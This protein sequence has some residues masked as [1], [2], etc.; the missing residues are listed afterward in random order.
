MAHKA[1]AFV[2]AVRQGHKTGLFHSWAET[3]VCVQGFSGAEHKKFASQEEA[4]RWLALKRPAPPPECE[5]PVQKRQR[6]T[7][8]TTIYCDGSC[9]GNGTPKAR[10]GIGVWFG[11]DD[12]RNL[13]EKLPDREEMRPNTNQKAELWA[14][15][16]ALQQLEPTEEAELWTD[17]QYT[18]N[19]AQK[20]RHAWKARQWR[21]QLTNLRLHRQLSDLM[22]QRTARTVWHYVPGHSGIAGNEAADA[23]AKQSVQ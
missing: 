5:E 2:Y 9:L 11:A 1:K 3:Q 19:S 4:E 22:D 15:I 17:S 23:L 6:Q 16:R 10:G 21:V 7:T 18:L 8:A 13:S 12:K 14:A 20:W